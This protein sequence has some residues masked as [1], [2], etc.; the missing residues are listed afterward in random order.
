M[1]NNEYEEYMRSILGYPISNEMNTYNTVY[2]NTNTFFPYRS[3]T[4]YTNE[5][6]YE[7]LY[8]EIYK[9]LKPMVTKICDNTRYESFSN[10][11]LEFIE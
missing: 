9:I 6:G 4:N 1:Y 3:G 5:N 7:N 11:A 2:E 10:D 8:P